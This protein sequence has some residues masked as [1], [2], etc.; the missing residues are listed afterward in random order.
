MDTV[1]YLIPFTLSIATFMYLGEVKWLKQFVVEWGFWETLDPTAV[2]FLSI[3]SLVC[4]ILI[5][6]Q[7][8]YRNRIG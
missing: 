4:I 8:L 7:C 2:V 3:M 6:R 1:L 5:V